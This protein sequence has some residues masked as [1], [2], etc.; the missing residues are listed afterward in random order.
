MTRRQS[1]QK[2][3]NELE[4]AGIVERNGLFRGGQPVY[5]LTKFS[6]KLGEMCPN[7]TDY[8]AAMNS[9]LRQQTKGEH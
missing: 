3:L 6:A 8:N 2:A 1:V 9:L 4:N 5:V 7:K